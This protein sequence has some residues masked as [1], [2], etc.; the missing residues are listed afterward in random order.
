MGWFR[1]GGSL[2]R[3]LGEPTHAISTPHH[4]RPSRSLPNVATLPDL[5]WLADSI[6][7][8]PIRSQQLLIHSSALAARAIVLQCLDQ[9]LYI[10]SAAITRL[11][12]IDGSGNDGRAW[13]W[14]SV[15]HGV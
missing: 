12:F 1:L 15:L 2:W 7:L 9:A 3:R 14:R 11:T 4:Y 10:A 6:G 13:L 8:C 5:H